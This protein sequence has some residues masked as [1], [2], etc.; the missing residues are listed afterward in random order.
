MSTVFADT[1]KKYAY[2][3]VRDYGIGIPKNKQD[4][5]FYPFYTTKQEGTG[6]GL[7]VVHKL[8]KDNEGIVEVDS[9]PNRGT[10]FTLYFK[11][12]PYE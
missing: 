1:T 2:I 7:Y 11:G 6:L 10:T 8:V 5:I 9:E 12:R 3:K 4:K